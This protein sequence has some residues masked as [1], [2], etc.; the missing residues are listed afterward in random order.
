M[1]ELEDD[2]FELVEEQRDWHCGG[3]PPAISDRELS[4]LVDECTAELCD[5]DRVYGGYGYALR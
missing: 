4:R 1:L 3:Y 2:D 5:F